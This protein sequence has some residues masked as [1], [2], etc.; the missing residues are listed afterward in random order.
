M[1]SPP[2]TTSPEHRQMRFPRAPAHYPAI[3]A[4]EPADFPC[5]S[6]TTLASAPRRCECQQPLS[7]AARAQI[8]SP[9]PLP[10]PGHPQMR[11]PRAPAHYPAIPATNPADFAHL[12]APPPQPCPP[13]KAP[14]P[15]NRGELQQAA[16]VCAAPTDATN[17]PATDSRPL[18]P[19]PEPQHPQ[20]SQMR[21]CLC[22]RRNR[23]LQKKHH[24][25][26]TKANCGKSLVSSPSPPTPLT[27]PPPMARFLAHQPVSQHP[28]YSQVLSLAPCGEGI[29]SSTAAPPHKPPRLLLP[30][31]IH[32]AGILP[33]SRFHP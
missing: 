30:N 31:W 21:M 26:R 14:P 15:T 4:T 27:H 16:C 23:V 18:T 12:L 9:W 29:Y 28:T 19:Q 24:H 17:P 3:P 6:T 10:S 22:H 20:R 32:I 5:L 7:V 33:L 13:G 2:P 1:H 11:F 8:H 25:H